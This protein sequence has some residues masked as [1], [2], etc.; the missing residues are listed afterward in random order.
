MVKT[1]EEIVQR[2]EGKV[3]I[4]KGTN[5]RGVWEQTPI[6]SRSDYNQEFEER[7]EEVEREDG[8]HSDNIN[9]SIK[10]QCDA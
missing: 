10:S 8:R 7:E 9:N 3:F 4:I 6:S 5:L 2:N 1:I